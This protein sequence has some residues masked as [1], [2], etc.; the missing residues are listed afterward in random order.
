MVRIGRDKCTWIVINKNGVQAWSK[1]IN[2][3][4]VHAPLCKEEP[5][6]VENVNCDQS[7]TSSE[8]GEI[9]ATPAKK[10]TVAK[11]T[12]TPAAPKKAAAAAS[13]AVVTDDA[14]PVPEKKALFT[15]DTV[16]EPPA[17][18]VKT[19]AAPKKLLKKAVVA[20]EE[21]VV[22]PVEPAAPK[23]ALKKIAEPAEAA[24]PEVAEKKKPVKKAPKA[25]D[26]EAPPKKVNAYLEFSKEMRPQVK[27]DFPDLSPKDIIK[28]IAEL[29]NAKK[30]TDKV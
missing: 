19:K 17:E 26:T 6:I 25:D 11:K 20:A 5:V 28:K 24:A 1:A 30:A 29:W 7:E 22:A 27:A 3:D 16:P 14:V 2:T 21:P 12:K 23:K 8:A 15:E 4:D 18:V 10:P 13:T 9:E